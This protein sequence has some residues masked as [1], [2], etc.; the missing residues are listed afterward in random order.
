MVEQFTRMRAG[1]RLWYQNDPAFTPAEVDSLQ[2]T[3]LSDLIKRNT[4]ISNIQD[5]A[6]HRPA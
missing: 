2:R 1:D 6:F 5:D 3:R 4:P